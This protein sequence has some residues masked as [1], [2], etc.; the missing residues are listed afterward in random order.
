MIAV[1]LRRTWAM[2]RAEVSLYVR[3][4]SIA[5]TALLLTPLLV[6]ANSPVILRDIDTISIPTVILQLVVNMSLMLVIYF[7]L[8]VIFVARR[9]DGV[10]QRLDTGEATRWETVVA[11]T[12][13]SVVVL[14]LQVVCGLV[15][16]GVI[17]KSWPISDP[18]LL[19]LTVLLALALFAGCAAFTSAYCRTVES[20]QYGA[21]PG[22]LFFYFLSGI[23]IPLHLFPEP[24]P[25]I[26]RWSPL[27]AVNHLLSLSSGTDPLTNQSTSFLGG[28]AQA[29]QP[30]AA[31][32]LWTVLFVALARRHMRFNRR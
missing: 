20:A 28:W 1:A 27:V 4:R 17:A 2:S 9:E 8:T 24:V 3:N 7:N 31:L 11:T 5:L 22:F 16:A 32:G 6:L 30:L 12:V 14:L 23:I 25:T 21:L 15:L 19:L 18:L 10:F 26:S 13:P 29:G